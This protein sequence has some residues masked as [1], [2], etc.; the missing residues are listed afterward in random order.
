[1]SV[2]I[3][4]PEDFFQ[5]KGVVPSPPPQATQV[6]E[7]ISWLVDKLIFLFTPRSFYTFFHPLRALCTSFLDILSEM[8]RNLTFVSINI[9]L[10]IFPFYNNIN[11]VRKKV[12]N[13]LITDRSELP[14]LYETS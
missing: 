3:T 6:L 1:M 11:Y 10:L 7:V 2:N 12:L 8:L 14:Q 5:P 13:F 4:L 9:Y